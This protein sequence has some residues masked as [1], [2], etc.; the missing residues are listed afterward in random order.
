MIITMFA[1][2]GGIAQLIFIF[3][4]FYSMWR[5]PK[6]P[7]NP[8]NSNT[9]EWTTPVEHIHGNWPGAIPEVHRWAY[10]YSK[11]GIS[12]RDYESP[13]GDESRT[14]LL[15]LRTLLAAL[16]DATD[17][18]KFAIET[19][20][21][22]RF[23]GYVERELVDT[24]GY[25]GLANRRRGDPEA[26][27]VRVMSFSILA[28]RRLHGLA[29]R[30]PSVLLMERVWP[31]Y[32]EGSLPRNTGIAGVSIEWVRAHPEYVAAVHDRGHAVHVWTVDDPEDVRRCERLG[33][34]AIISNRPAMVR[35]VLG[36]T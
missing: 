24:L 29:P 13:S 12:W 19:K 28:V 8:W 35:G 21:P 11:P 18:I 25:F 5:G 6:A 4:F 31:W 26:T 7:Q 9:L 15:T 30:I 22:T 36:L 1:I 32:R 23:G 2:G 16:L 27:R 34:E 10:D 33:V 14:G 3:N 20:H 17:T